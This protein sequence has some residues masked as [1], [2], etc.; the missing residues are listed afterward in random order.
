MA[1]RSSSQVKL[2]N[3]D[4]EGKKKFATFLWFESWDWILCG[5]GYWDD[6]VDQVKVSTFEVLKEEFGAVAKMSTTRVDSVQ[7]PLYNQIRFLDQHGM[8]LINIQN[9]ELAASMSSKADT[10]WF[11]AI[12]ETKPGDIVFSPLE[13]AAN[14]GKAELRVSA[15]IFLGKTFKGGIVLSLDWGLTWEVFKKRVYGNTGY[16]YIIDSAGVLITHPKYALKDNKS[17]VDHSNP[18]LTRIVT[19]QMLKGVEGSGEYRFEGV[20]KIVTFVP[21]KIGNAIYSIAATCPTEEFMGTVNAMRIEAERKRKDVLKTVAA[22]ALLMAAFGFF[23]AFWFSRSISRPIQEIT[24]AATSMEKGNIRFILEHQGADEIGALASAFRSLVDSQKH[25]IAVMKS[26]SEGDLSLS[27]NL[28]SPEDELNQAL[29]AMLTQMSQTLSSVNSMA[30][31][32]DSG[33]NQISSASQSL[34]EGAT[35][36][37]ASIEE[38]ASS[39]AEIG[40]QTKVNAD[41]AGKA[42]ARAGEARSAAEKGTREVGQMVDSMKDM[43]LSGQQIVKIVK[44]IDDIAFQTNL[45]ALNAAVE[46]ARAGAHGKGFAVVAD[47]VRNLAGRSAKAAKETADLVEGIVKKMDTSSGMA[48]ITQKSLVEILD[49]ATKVADYI[50]RIAASSNEQANGISQIDTGLAQINQ[51]TQQNSANAEETAASSQDLARQASDLRN[52]MNRFKLP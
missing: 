33:V 19:E 5:S 9:G 22:I 38:I 4:F 24:N 46:A 16:P 34:S 17:I 8:E 7:I 31:S 48:E 44:M 23:A 6:C 32:I 26:L 14:T 28:R 45:L 3:Y 13:I 29:S 47:E 18:E 10:P 39:V 30:E 12:K 25:E 1:E 21:F 35:N 2:T 41:N 11:K 42:N 52:L 27:V 43:K 37:A 49:H 36:Q 51:V 15:P 20:A 40:K 50:S